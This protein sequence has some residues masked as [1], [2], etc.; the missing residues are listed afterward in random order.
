MGFGFCERGFLGA[1]VSAEALLICE[2]PGQ[3]LFQLL[4]P[5]AARRAAAQARA[6]QASQ[7]QPAIQSLGQLN[8]LGE[9]GA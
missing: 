5:A 3:Q 2:K 7:V 1:W 4:Q 8:Q 6:A 9:V